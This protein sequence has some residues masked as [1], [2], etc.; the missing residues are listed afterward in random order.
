MKLRRLLVIAPPPSRAGVD[1]FHRMIPFPSGMRR[2]CDDA[3]DLL[4]SVT[5]AEVELHEGSLAS[6]PDADL[7]VLYQTEFRRQLRECP[8]GMRGRR[9]VRTFAY[10]LAD[11]EALEFLDEYRLAGSTEAL[12]SDQW[13][14]SS[15]ATLFGLREIAEAMGGKLHPMRKTDDY[16]VFRHPAHDTLASLFP[17]YMDRYLDLVE[18]RVQPTPVRP[19]TSLELSLYRNLVRCRACGGKLGSEVLKPTRDTYAGDAI[20]LYEGVCPTCGA[21][22]NWPYYLPGDY[23]ATN[24]SPDYGGVEPSTIIDPSQFLALFDQ[25]VAAVRESPA[26][27]SRR[28]FFDLAPPLKRAQRYL[29]E[30]AKFL[31][32]GAD[33]IPDEAFLTDEGRAAKRAAPHRFTRAYLEGEMARLAAIRAEYDPLVP[34]HQADAIAENPLP[35]HMTPAAI[36]A[37]QEWLKRGRTGNGQ[38]SLIEDDLRKQR[39]ADWKLPAVR[40]RR[41]ILDDMDLTFS[42]WTDCVWIDCSAERIVCQYSEVR[43]LT[44]ERCKMNRADFVLT[45]MSAVTISECDL[46]GAVFGR[47]GYSSLI[48]SHSSFEYSAFIEEVLTDSHFSDCDFRGANLGRGLT[49][50]PDYGRMRRVLFERCDL[51]NVRW[52]G[53]RLDGIVFVDCRFHGGHGTPVLEG[54]ISVI[55]GDFSLDGDGSLRGDERDLRRLWNVPG[56]ANGRE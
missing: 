47:G 3:V 6:A 5:E 22:Q 15:T 26:Q 4:R 20:G 23:T 13:H 25:D 40:F 38:L 11:K 21:E 29:A 17:A 30:V 28:E 45:N 53:K 49:T 52:D 16:V 18:S 35:K 7:Y 27:L 19:R 12:A 36:A 9:A 34:K 24:P 10:T 41:C 51:R 14:S 1:S 46:S 39:L 33:E 8:D 32:P 50:Y 31:P 54:K 55:N 2:L 48:A 37:H 42:T 44:L 56:S 43:N